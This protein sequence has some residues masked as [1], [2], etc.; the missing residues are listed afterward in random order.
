MRTIEKQVFHYDELSDKAKE[1]ARDWFRD[2]SAYDDWYEFVYEDAEQ[3]GNILG[4]TLDTKRGNTPTIYFSGFSSQGDG[5]CFEGSY[6]Y[7]KG[8]VKAI[9]AY[10]PKDEELHRIA[11]ALQ[12]IQR[13]NFYKLEATCKHCGHY[14]HSGCM[15]VSVSHVDDMYRTITDDAEEEVTQLMRDFADWIYGQLEKEYEYQNSDEVV[16]ENIIA[17]EYEFDEEGYLA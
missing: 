8:A 13:R 14:Y 15:D 12:E 17:N 9:K 1:M 5:A 16:E 4:I 3:V 7:V 6:S 11:K 2:T 10:A